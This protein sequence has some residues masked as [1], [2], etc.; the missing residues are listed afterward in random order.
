M[1]FLKR[2]S[3]KRAG[4]LFNLIRNQLGITIKITGH[5]HLKGHLIE[6][7]LAGSHG[8]GRSKQASE[9]PYMSFVTVRL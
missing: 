7:I 6:Q 8:C 3:A 2:P 1:D 4:E 9:C 5:C